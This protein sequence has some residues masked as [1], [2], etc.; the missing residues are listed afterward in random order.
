MTA[1][2]PLQGLVTA[3]FGRHYQVESGGTQIECV[4][5]GKR[6]GIACGDHVVFLPT[7]AGQGVIESILPRHNLLHRSVAHRSKLIAANVSRI[8]I[9][10]APVPS[11]YDLLIN[12]CL[13]AAEAAAIPALICLNKY[14]LGE[15]AYAAQHRLEPYIKL[16]YPLLALS[17]HQDISALRPYLSGQISVFVGQ[18]GMGKSSLINA[19]APE[20]RTTVGEVSEA[21][22]SGRH[23]T[24]GAR[25]YKLDDSS[26]LIDSPG[27]QEFGL[28]HIEPAQLDRYFI[29]FR[30]YIGHCRF[31]NCRHLHEPDCA[32][33]QAAAAGEITPSRLTAYRQILAGLKS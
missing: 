4:S 3:T 13:V 2:L 19:L 8:V 7:S 17:A 15:P 25:M 20:A 26:R 6:S 10:V 23:T 27:M 24:T 21:L 16:G 18:S 28:N 9:V 31:S 33:T 32:V 12:R 11:F 1:P 30:P 29:E 22:D 5:R 14:D